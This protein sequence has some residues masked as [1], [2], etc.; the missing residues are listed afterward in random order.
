MPKYSFDFSVTLFS[1]R[2]LPIQPMGS[3]IRSRTVLKKSVSHVMS[4]HFGRD[5]AFMS[6]SAQTPSLC[7]P[8]SSTD[9]RRVDA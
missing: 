5:D 9:A 2:M 8:R 1:R 3:I 4:Q 6:P 7:L